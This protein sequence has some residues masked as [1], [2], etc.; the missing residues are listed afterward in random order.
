MKLKDK[1]KQVRLSRSNKFFQSIF[2]GVDTLKIKANVTNEMIMD[3]QA[4]HGYDLVQELENKMMYLCTSV[5]S[6]II[7]LS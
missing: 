1:I 6:V 7:S 5:I 4:Q 2:R 3:L